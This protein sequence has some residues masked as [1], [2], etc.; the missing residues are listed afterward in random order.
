MSLTTLS[1]HHA[2]WFA[3]FNKSYG[4]SATSAGALDVTAINALFDRYAEEG[5][6][7]ILAEGIGRFCEDLEVRLKVIFC[8]QVYILRC[9]L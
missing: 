3:G 6:D 1:L 4:S 2:V 7:K 5:H 8:I 9:F